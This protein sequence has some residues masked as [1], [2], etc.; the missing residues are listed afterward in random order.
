MA[1][2]INA[3]KARL[4]ERSIQTIAQLARMP[5]WSLER[6]VGRAIGEKLTALAWNRHGQSKRTAGHDRPEPSRR[7]A[8][9]L[10]KSRFFGQR[11]VTLPTGSPVGCGRS[12]GRGGR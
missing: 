1:Q 5:G 7:S 6:V 9:S 4:N 10:R 2:T 8:G 11:C 12:R 3:A